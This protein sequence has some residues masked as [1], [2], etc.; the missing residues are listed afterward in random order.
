MGTFKPKRFRLGA[1]LGDGLGERGRGDT[2]RGGD[3]ERRRAELLRLGEQCP[4]SDV[5]WAGFKYEDVLEEGIEMLLAE[6]NR[7]WREPERL[8]DDGMG[9]GVVVVGR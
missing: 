4:V 1:W 5:C 8:G 9:F 6:R 7:D 2:G 3:I